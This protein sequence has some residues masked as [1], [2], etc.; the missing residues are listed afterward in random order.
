MTTTFNQDGY[1]QRTPHALAICHARWGEHMDPAKPPKRDPCDGCPLYSPCI[2]GNASASHTQERFNSW[3]IKINRA[4][5][6]L[7]AP[8]KK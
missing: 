6:M 3:I 4:A 5:E 1:A 8:A 7:P 2:H